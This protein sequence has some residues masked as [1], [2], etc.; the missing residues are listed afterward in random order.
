[1]SVSLLDQLNRPV[2]KT[3]K[4]M[5][6]LRSIAAALFFL[7]CHLLLPAGSRADSPTEQVRTTVDKVL[8]I[9]R[10]PNP[11]SKIQ[12]ESQRAQ[13]VE[14]ISLRFDFTEMAKRSLGRHWARRSQEEQRQFVKVFSALMVRSYADNIETYTG[15]N[16]LYT[17]ETEDENYAEVDTR[18]VTENHPP[19]TINYKLHSVNK[20][21]KVYDLVIE[22]VSVVNNYRSQ[23][24]RVIAKTSYA[25]LVRMLKDKQS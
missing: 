14:V 12:M 13:L 4:R 10:S 16:V 11:K 15:K 5:P 19:L 17:R 23:F 7:L 3:T 9:V 8:A 18:I 21:W 24:D 25:D 20:G 2:G 22:D 6:P 1:M